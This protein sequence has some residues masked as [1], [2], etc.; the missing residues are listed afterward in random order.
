MAPIQNVTLQAGA[1]LEIPV[2]TTNSAG[3]PVTYTVSTTNAAINTY[4]PTTNPYLQLTISHASS[5]QPGDTSFSGT[6]VIEL[7]QDLAPKTVAQIESLT[8]QG[9]YNGVVFHRI[10]SGFVDQAGIG[11]SADAGINVPTID[12]EIV[13]SLRYTSAG[14]LGM[15]RTTNDDTNTSQFF[16]TAAAQPFLDYQYTIFGRVVSDPNNL[17][18]VMNSVPVNSNSTPD[19]AVT[20][21]DAKIIQDPFDVA[22]QIGVPESTTTGSGDVT[23]TANDGHGG[24]A[25]QTFHVTIQADAND[26]SPFLQNITPI[27]TSANTPITF[28]LS[29]FNLHGDTLTYYN[30]NGLQ[31]NFGLSPSQ[32][33]N[34]NIQVSVNSSTGQVTVTPTNNFVG[35]AAIFVGVN[36]KS[37]QNTSPS[38]RMIPLFVN[39]AA[40]TGFTLLGSSDTGAS[41]SD[42]VTTRNN[43]SAATELQFQVSGVTAGNT[44]ELFDGS[45]KIFSMT[46]P[47][48]SFVL[49]TDAAHTL[50]D[51]AHQLSIRQVLPAAQSSY[52]VGN[53]S[54]T[55]VLASDL[56]SAVAVTVDTSTPAFTSTPLTSATVGSQYVY[57]ANA[58]DS[59][60]TSLTYSLVKAPAGMTVVASSGAVSWTPTAA[61]HGSQAVQL[62]ATDPAGNFIVQ[63]FNVV[64]GGAAPTIAPIADQTVT[65]GQLLQFTAQASDANP[66]DTFTFSLGSGSPQG[67]AINPTTGVFSWSPTSAQAG[68]TY[69]IQLVVLDSEGLTGTQNVK[70]QVLSGVG[71]PNQPP[72]LPTIVPQVATVG[73]QFKLLVTASD[74]DPSDTF[75]YGLGT[76][77]PSGVAINPTTGLVT[78]TPITTQAS[79]TYP[80]TVTVTDAGGLS[81]QTTFNVTIKAA[82]TGG[83]QGLALGAA[84]LGIGH[85]ALPLQAP[86]MAATVAAASTTSFVVSPSVTSRAGF[87]TFSDATAVNLGGAG[88]VAAP[89]VTKKKATDDSG[90]D[91]QDDSQAAGDSNSATDP[92]AASDPDAAKAGRNTR[93]K[94]QKPANLDNSD[95]FG[96]AASGPTSG[97]KSSS[98]IGVE[99]TTSHLTSGARC[100]ATRD[101]RSDVR[102]IEV[103]Q[104]AARCGPTGRHLRLRPHVHVG[105]VQCCR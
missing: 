70:V 101:G 77:S 79:S 98:A 12:N 99:Q 103:P 30:Q 37:A 21:T 47:S 40:P 42:G 50:A 87:A 73:S 94:Q 60:S 35:V 58:T 52:T 97:D 54:G 102:A 59:P 38:T 19:S 63:S 62:Q 82:S 46:A 65:A 85:V 7:F 93:G 84:E 53:T 100:R 16:I 80:I 15:A 6:M 75:S 49:T 72:T 41:S 33:L 96:P 51:G 90:A 28:Q 25:S 39:P 69:T 31:T 24:V 32:T 2:N 57:N 29:A 71:T 104:L 27:T 56:S 44:I 48:A 67:A 43:S 1:P 9:F 64:V 18:Q 74:T 23:V 11:T 45:T 68:T 61:Q 89:V 92:S 10:V 13:S 26:A 22:L 95:P 5:G 34:P 76:G 17:V 83:T 91:V 36:S 20:I 8:N 14:V 66:N 105:A 4:L 86:G 3:T 78:W 88:D 55:A 81:A